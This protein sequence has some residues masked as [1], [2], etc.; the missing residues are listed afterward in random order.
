MPPRDDPPLSYQPRLPQRRD[1]RIGILGAGFIVRDCHLVAYRQAGFQPFAIASRNPQRAEA[2]AQQHGVPRVHRT[3][4]DVMA[5]PEVEV[6]DI[7]VPPDVQPELIWQAVRHHDHIRGILA[8]KPL[9]MSYRLAR[10]CVEAC[11]AAG[12]VLAVNQNMRYDQSVRALR[13]LLQR[14]WLGEPVLATIE[15]RAIPHWMPWSAQLPSLSTFIMSIHHLDTFRFWFGTPDRVL[16]STRS[17]PRTSFPHRDGINLYILEYD[18]GLRA[19]AW[20]DVWSGPCREGSGSDIAIRWRVEGTD[21]LA[22]GT[23]G[24]PSYPARAPSTLDYTTRRHGGEWVQPRWEEVWF[25]DAFV[26]TMAQLLCALEEGT[27][28]EIS[29]RDNLETIALCAAVYAA[30]TE[31]RVTTVAEFASETA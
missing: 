7:A 1:F 13:D 24:W 15:M 30:A 27:E 22:K 12:I 4:A 2:V 16:A 26:G 17:D 8:Q 9:A 3:Y 23:I 11:A 25:P 29:G 20:D 18:R 6:L 31:H 10:E 5:D 14:G 19:A 28:P 21:G